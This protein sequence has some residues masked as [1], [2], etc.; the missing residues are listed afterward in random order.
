MKEKLVSV[1]VPIYNTGENICVLLENL[2]NGS[3]KNLEIICIDDGSTDN[4]MGLVIDFA[5]KHPNLPLYHTSSEK[6]IGEL[7]PNHDSPILRLISKENGGPSSARNV[8][9]NISRGEYLIFVDSDD[10]V[11]KNFVAEMVKTLDNEH[12][13]M[14]VCGVIYN[15]VETKQKNKIFVNTLKKQG[16]NESKLEYVLRLL[17]TDGRLYA[18]HNKIYRA[19]IIREKKLLFDEKL[20]FAEDLK[21]NL[22]YTNY[23]SGD[24]NFMHKALY[25]YNYGTPTSVVRKSSILA[26]NWQ[27]SFEHLKQVAKK[28]KTGKKLSCKEKCRMR[29]IWLRWKVSHTRNVMKICPTRK[30]RLKHAN[31]CWYIVVKIF[32]GGLERIRSLKK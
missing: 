24:I 20:N 26:K 6:S 4:T 7:P 21:F 1:I 5:Y 9:I 28:M 29:L 22:E 18:V 14:G 8:G 11:N 12:Y 17:L 31:W 16:K 23:A 2:I 32:Y 27:K 15:Q 3:Y 25:Q 19:A 30:E 13:D 10:N